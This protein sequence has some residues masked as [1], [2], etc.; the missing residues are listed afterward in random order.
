MASSSS[1]DGGALL[2]NMQCIW[3]FKMWN[4][5]HSSK[6]I[7]S[8]PLNS[9]SHLVIAHEYVH[10]T[11]TA[12]KNVI[13][14]IIITIIRPRYCCPWYVVYLFKI[15]ILLCVSL[16]IWAKHNQSR[17][18]HTPKATMMMIMLRWCEDHHWKYWKR[19]Q[20][21]FCSALHV[22][23]MPQAKVNRVK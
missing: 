16:F 6:M 17:R 22:Q 5:I 11:H 18:T 12:E 10:I 19:R 7:Q 4:Y 1:C 20:R 8:N 2:Q 13:I 23:L 21:C 9:I 14:I 3:E 15:V